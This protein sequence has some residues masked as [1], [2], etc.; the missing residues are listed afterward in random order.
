MASITCGNC[1][2]T[3]DSTAAVR[4]CYT[5]GTAIGGCTWM[6]PARDEDGPIVI[7]CGA[8]AFATERGWYCVSGHEHVSVLARVEEGWDYAEDAG[9]AMTLVRAGLQPFTMDGHIAV[10]PENFTR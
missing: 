3:H 7:E 5:E 9:D 4:D 2:N 6:V 10:C 1:R 8:P